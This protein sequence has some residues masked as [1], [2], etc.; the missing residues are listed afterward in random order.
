M[1]GAGRGAGPGMP[2]VEE[3][4]ET[5]PAAPISVT[6][7]AVDTHLQAETRVNWSPSSETGAANI[8][9]TLTL[10]VQAVPKSAVDVKLPIHVELAGAADTWFGGE[11][12]FTLCP[13]TEGGS[14]AEE[15]VR[16]NDAASMTEYDVTQPFYVQYTLPEGCTSAQT[17]SG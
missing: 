15:S 10:T 13:A 11:L 2:T 17:P 6:L 14:S 8:T 16:F 4:A 9:V 3:T 12:S 7:G 1:A 5:Q